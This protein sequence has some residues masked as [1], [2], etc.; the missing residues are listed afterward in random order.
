[1]AI[2]AFG[3][4][5]PQIGNDTYIDES[6]QV[7]G[8]V[9]IGND[10]SI[11]PNTSIRGDVNWIKIGDATNIQDGSVLHVTHAR[12][13]QGHR[14]QAEKGFSLTIGNY[15]TVGHKVMLHGCTIDDFCLIGMG[16]VVMDGAVIEK[17]VFLGAGSLVPPGKILQSGF[18]YLGSPARKIRQ[19]QDDEIANF[20]YSA[21]QYIKLK[22][23][24]L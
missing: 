12:Q 17:N 3:K 7:I 13:A 24:Y 23:Q 21:K 8:Q 22:N 10:S 20:R 11:W 4:H 6:A 14:D 15:V 9:E 2:R 1:M 16:A 5:Q 19:L 18:L